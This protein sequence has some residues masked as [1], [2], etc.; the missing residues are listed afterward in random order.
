MTG[1]GL[2]GA[3]PQFKHH[4]QD[5]THALEVQRRIGCV[6]KNNVEKTEV[7]LSGDTGEM[8]G[9]GGAAIAAEPCSPRGS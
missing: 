1:E 8:S 9:E 5:A 2:L 4:F 6:A 3:V 7:I